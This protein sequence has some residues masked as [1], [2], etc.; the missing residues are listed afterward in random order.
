LVVVL[1]VV[2]AGPAIA[3]KCP[4]LAGAPATADID[5]EVR[6]QLISRVL[7]DQNRKMRIWNWIWGLTFTTASAVQYGIAYES[8]DKDR[9][10]DLV[11]GGSKAFIGAASVVLLPLKVAAAPF[12]TGLLCADLAAAEEALV[13]GARQQ[14]KGR[15]L[16][17]HA[18]GLALNTVTV[19]IVGFG[20]DRWKEGLI[21]AAIG[22]LVGEIRIFTQPT[23][24]RDTLSDYR[25]G[26][27][28]GQSK[29]SDVAWAVVP[30]VSPDHVGGVLMLAF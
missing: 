13:E 16:L 25:A 9:R 21:G 3:E 6:L 2:A 24:A 29:S 11:A 18:E 15:R 19:L 1:V 8:D 20:Y 30:V 4:E 26:K 23:D 22:T 7:D 14:H 10:V 12:G 28:S 17:R 27:L 5:G